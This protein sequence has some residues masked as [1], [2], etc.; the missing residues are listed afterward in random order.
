[1]PKAHLYAD[2]LAAVFSA[3]PHLASQVIEPN[4]FP[5][6]PPAKHPQLVDSDFATLR[7]W[8][9]MCAP[10]M[11]DDASCPMPDDAGTDAE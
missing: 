8:F 11:P 5:H 4:N 2:V 1:M 9:A 3:S 6:M 7:S 10:P